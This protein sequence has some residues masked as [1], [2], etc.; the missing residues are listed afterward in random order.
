MFGL[1]RDASVTDHGRTE[2]GATSTEYGLLVGFIAFAIIF[3]VT[4]F[5]TS[6]D[7]WYERL[8]AVVGTF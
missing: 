7:S 6:V 1:L 4:A 8:A 3:G 2:D 5:G